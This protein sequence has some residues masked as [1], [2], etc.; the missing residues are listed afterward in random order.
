MR[1]LNKGCRGKD[2][3]TLQKILNL[4]VDGIFGSLTEEAVKEFQKQHGLYPDGIVGEKTWKILLPSDNPYDIV[5]SKRKITEIIVHCTATRE[6]RP[7]TIAE[8]TSWHK[9]RGFS[10]I[11]YHYV[12][13]IDGTVC[14]GRDVNVSGAHCVG[15]NSNSIGVCYVG[16]LDKRNGEEKDT[17]TSAQKFSMLNLLKKLKALYPNAKIYGHC[18][19]SN[20]KCPCFDAKNEY[21]NI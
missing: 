3:E 18:D 6:G 12:V 21:R 4:Y 11:G 8:I 14:K 15:H 5:K 2:V 16:G 1:V 13:M 17:R 19:F 20:K 9:Q 7:T 10:T